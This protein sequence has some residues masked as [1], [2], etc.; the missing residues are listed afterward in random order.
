MVYGS[1]MFSWSGSVL[2]TDP[3]QPLTTAECEEPDGVGH[4]LPVDGLL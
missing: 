4:D 3:A 2:C 1:T